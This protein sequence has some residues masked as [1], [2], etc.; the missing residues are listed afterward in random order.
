MQDIKN[1]YKHSLSPSV[2]AQANRAI[3]MTS[4]FPYQGIIS[5]EEG[6]REE[7]IRSLLFNVTVQM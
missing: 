3:F 7:N 6:V 2:Y 4:R 5:R 1:D